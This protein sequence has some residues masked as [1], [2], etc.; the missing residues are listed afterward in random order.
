MLFAAAHD[1]A[2]LAWSVTGTGDPLLL[3]SG[4][5]VDSS[6][7]DAVLPVFSARHQVITFD[8]RGTGASSAGG[9]QGYTTRSFARDARA[10]LD[11]AGVGQAH[12]YG[13]SMGG[14]V[15]QWL[16]L[17][18]PERVG[19]LILGATT[20]GDTRGFPRTPAATADLASADPERLARLFFE[21]PGLR[22]DAKA[23]F[24][25]GT[26]RRQRR[27]HFQA[28]RAH[29]TWDQVSGIT[30]PT[31]VLHGSDDAL[32]PPANGERL[33]ELIPRAQLRILTGARHGYYLEHQSASAAALEFLAAHSLTGSL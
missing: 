8:H 29:D 33:A 32:T 6:A 9:E 12:V 27:L 20:G 10:V 5:G 19:A 4:Q 7:W 23:F 28:S 16:A 30:A 1:G 24:A 13:H 25:P 2:S 21:G 22:D 15:A 18:A 14:R 26:A 3:I 17:D 11:A 31:L